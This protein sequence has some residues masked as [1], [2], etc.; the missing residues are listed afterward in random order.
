MVNFVTNFILGLLPEIIYFTLFL[1]YTKKYK[2]NKFKLFV[3][4]LIGYTLFEIIF[5]DNIYFQICFTLYVPLVLKLLYKDKFHISDIF[6]FVYASII[7]IIIT[8]ITAPISIISD[9]YW[10]GYI[11][12]RIIMFGFLYL[13]RKKLNKVYKWIIS[14][15]NRNYEH[16]NKIKAITIRQICVISLNIMIFVLYLFIQLL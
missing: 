12:D 2:Y 4:L 10:I 11:F 3:L 15:W 5:P 8:C 7:L 6:I 13:F 9:N 16:P 14:Q 1:I